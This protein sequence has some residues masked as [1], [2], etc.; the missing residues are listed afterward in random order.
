MKYKGFEI[1]NTGHGNVKWEA[2]DINGFAKF[3]SE[4]KKEIIQMIDEE[5]EKTHGTKAN[6]T[7]EALELAIQHGDNAVIKRLTKITKELEEL[8]RLA[9]IGKAVE[10]YMTKCNDSIIISGGRG[11]RKTKYDQWVNEI[12]KLYRKE[13]SNGR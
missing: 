10:W 2:T 8:E 3:H 13:V 12:L 1:F 7:K 6:V 11:S 9:E 4:T 5:I